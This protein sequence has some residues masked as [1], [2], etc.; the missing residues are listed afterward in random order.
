MN[1]QLAVPIINIKPLRNPPSAQ[2]DATDQALGNAT[3][4]VGAA[5]LTGLPEAAILTMERAVQLNAIFELPY[6][7][8]MT[9]ALNR[10][11]PNAKR[12]WRG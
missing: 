8:K 4:E 10:I 7:E 11:D 9:V 6:D 2:R 5:V 1:N 3:R 12:Y